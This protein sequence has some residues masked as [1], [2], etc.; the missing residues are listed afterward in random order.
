MD[1]SGPSAGMGGRLIWNLLAH[2]DLNLSRF[3]PLARSGF[4]VV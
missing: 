4:R 3:V 1:I 2:M